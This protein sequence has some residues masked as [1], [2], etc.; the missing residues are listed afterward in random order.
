[1]CPGNGKDD[2]VISRLVP[3]DWDWNQAGP[4]SL[5]RRNDRMQQN[6][7]GHHETFGSFGFTQR[8]QRSF[9]SKKLLKGLFSR[10]PWDLMLKTS[11]ST[12]CFCQQSPFDKGPG[13]VHPSLGTPLMAIVPD[14]LRLSSNTSRCDWLWIKDKANVKWVRDWSDDWS[15]AW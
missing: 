15:D 2:V 4:K 3:P 5:R 8:S 10:K 13:E 11:V 14:G 7:H 1:M 12:Q 9:D 6:G